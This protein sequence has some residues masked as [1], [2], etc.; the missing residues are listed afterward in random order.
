MQ[1]SAFK[2]YVRRDFKR[3]DKDTELVQAYND[4]LMWVQAMMPHGDYKFQSYI[5]TVAGQEDYPL[6]CD[7]MHLYHPIRLLLGTGSS[8][9]GYPLR[10]VTE[11]QDYDRHYPNPNRTNPTTARP[12]SYTIWSRSILLGPVPDLAT[13]LIEI[14]WAKR[15]AD[16]SGDT[17]QPSLREEWDEVLKHGTLE[18]LYEGLSQFEEAQ[19]W[20]AKYHT[21]GPDGRDVPVG[22]CA[23]LFERER[24]M[25]GETVGVVTPNN[26]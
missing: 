9:A 10:H 17:E 1:L 5:F 2:T 4:M 21:P 7:I 18:R 13:Y 24:N 3:T 25:E 22:L 8:D 20:G 14:N 19:Y 26:L 11:K 23:R 16:L 6:P 12:S 15:A